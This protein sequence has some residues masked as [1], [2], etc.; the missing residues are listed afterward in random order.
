MQQGVLCWFWEC[1]R[2]F[3]DL[4]KICE[5][6]MCVCIYIC[7]YMRVYIHVCVCVRKIGPSTLFMS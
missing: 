2:G 5:A 7:I 3:P 6:C 4:P 1:L